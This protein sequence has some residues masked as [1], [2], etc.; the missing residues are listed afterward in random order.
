MIHSRFKGMAGH[1]LLHC[2]DCPLTG[3]PCRPGLEICQRL[4]AAMALAGAAVGR[5]LS[6]SGAAETIC[7]GTPCRIVWQAGADG[8]TVSGNSPDD[9]P[10]EAHAPRIVLGSVPGGLQ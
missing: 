9:T 6:L 3:G 1:R 5:E 7:D 4:R 10:D 8:V 2:S